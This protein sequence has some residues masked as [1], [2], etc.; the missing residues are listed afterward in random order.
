MC[1]LEPIYYVT[2]NLQVSNLTV[3]VQVYAGLQWGLENKKRLDRIKRRTLRGTYPESLR[4]RKGGGCGTSLHKTFGHA[5]SPSQMGRPR[6]SWSPWILAIAW[7]SWWLPPTKTIEYKPLRAWNAKKLM[8]LKNM[9]EVR[10]DS[11]PLR[12]DQTGELWSCGEGNIH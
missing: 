4:W 5:E 6:H 3:H 2:S 7:A 8:R 1:Y 9:G 11:R 10:L 12:A